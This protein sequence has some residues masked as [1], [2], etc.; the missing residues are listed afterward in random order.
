M[1]LVFVLEFHDFRKLCEQALLKQF[2]MH[3]SRMESIA[4]RFEPGLAEEEQD[5]NVKRRISVYRN[6]QQVLIR[7]RENVV[8][9]IPLHKQS[10]SNPRKNM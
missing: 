5:Q 7:R 4:C 8:E 2:F 1:N 10:V 6:E 9:T 3:C